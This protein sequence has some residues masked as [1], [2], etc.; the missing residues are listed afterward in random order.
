MTAPPGTHHFPPPHM[1]N[2]NEA[3][4][5]AY[6]GQQVGE[7]YGD[8][9]FHYE[10]IYH[11]NQGDPPVRRHE[12]AV[13]FLSGGTPREAERLFGELL[14]EGHATTERAYYYVLSVVSDRSFNDLNGELL[15]RIV[16]ARKMCVS[17]PRDD[18][19][20]AFDV[21]WRLMRHVRQEVEGDASGEEQQQ[22]LESFHALRTERQDEIVLHLDMIMSG[23]LQE[24]L[25]AR[26]AHRVV[27]ERMRDGRA[28]RAWKFFQADPAAPREHVPAPSK[29]APVDWIRA[30]LGSAVAAL[31]LPDTMSQ[32]WSVGVLVAIPLL[33]AGG[34]FLVRHGITREA[35]TLY[36]MV[37]RR[38]VMPPAQPVEARSPGHWVST[39]F[40]QEIHELVD[41]HFSKARPHDPGDWPGYTF[42]IRTHLKRRLVDLYGNAQ[43]TPAALGWLIDW[44]ARRV[45]AGWSTQALFQPPVVMSRRD[46]NLFRTGV[47]L[48]VVGLAALVSAGLV[49]SALF[50]GIGGFFVVRGTIRILG[51]RKMDNILAADARRLHAEEMRA[52]QEWLHVL[53]DRPSDAEMA[54]WLAMDKIYLRNDALRRANL[55]NHDLV[56]HVVMTEGAKD[57][58][59]A[60]VLHGPPR[61]SKYVVQIFLLTRGGVREAR[62]EL[63]FLTGE[64]KNERRNLFRY[65]ALASATV[66]ET[67][68]RTTRGEGPRTEEVERLRRRTFQLTLVNGQN[69]TV[70]AENFRSQ[71]ESLED[72]SELFLVALQ[73]SGIETALPILEAVA[74]E[75]PDWIAREQERRERWSRDWYE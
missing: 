57:A 27:T 15:A 74:S 13:N 20:D 3:H 16:S 32:L 33:V 62:V 73:A 25:E 31:V 36:T 37:R 8:T 65:D 54:R 61:Y 38:E 2:H 67:G 40:V 14:W 75:G 42:G 9:A 23:V 35:L 70:M 63:D 26:Q 68:V 24:R 51:L 5:G 59:R 47:A 45:A 7:H 22:A 29:S 58:M 48:V 50:L 53:S 72:D 11:I 49:L 12:V 69:I 39:A 6:V 66:N 43:V 52:Y 71:A 44:H 64:A 41:R 56:A 55:P 28:A 34:Y 21:V 4:S 30:L 46:Q 1:H 19:W 60:R 18:W 17:L 10:S